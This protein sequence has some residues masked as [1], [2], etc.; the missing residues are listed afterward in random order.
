MSF[1][2]QD[3]TIIQK[4]LVD[5]SVPTKEE[6]L[7][8]EH[9]NIGAV[10]KLYDDVLAIRETLA[11]FAK[12][13]FDIPL[14][15]RGAVWGHLK[16][17]QA[18]LKHLAWQV[19]QVAAGDLSQRVD[20]MGDFSSAFNK[21]TQQLEDSLEKM[22][23]REAAERMQI[24]FDAT[25]LCCSFWNE[26]QE[27]LDCNLEAVK[28]HELDNKR[29]YCERFFDLSPE[30]QPDGRRSV[31][32]FREKLN[33]AFVEGYTQCEFLR[34][35]INGEP[36]PVEITFVRVLQQEHYIVACY[37]R[38]LRELK[39]QQAALDRQRQLLLDVFSSSP[40][41]FAILADGKVKF[42]SAFMTHF[43]GLNIDDPFIDCF[44][45]KEKGENLLSEVKKE[46]H[47]EWEPVTLCSK[48]HGVKEMLANLFLTEYYGEQGMIVWLVDVTEIKM[49]EAD[50][51]AAKETAERLGLVKDE[52]I[53]NMSHELR[54]PMNAVLG[55]IHLLHHTNLSEEQVSFV[56]TM[57]ASA[58][59]L[60]QIINDVLDFSK[61]ESGKV[62]MHWEDF[63]VRETLTS[64]Q[65]TLREDVE[66]KNLSLSCSIEEGVPTSLSGDPERLRQVLL[67][68]TDNA[69]KF[70]AE[71]SV[72]IRV[73]L[74]SSELEKVI[75][76]FSV[77]DTGIGMK[78]EDKEQIFRP[79]SQVDTSGTRKYGGTGLGLT[80][81]KSLVELMGGRIWSE[82]ELQRG[83][84]FFFTA[85]FKLPKEK[86]P[87]EI[88]F[89]ESFQGLPVLLAEDN[90]INQIVATK[91]L[92]E[93]GFRVDV[94]PN[95]LRAVEMVKQ[96]DYALVFMD[97]QMPEMDG[98]QATQIIRSDAKYAFLPIVALTANAM[99]DDR[100]QCLEAGMNDHVAKPIEPEIL[101]RT[102]LRW[103]NPVAETEP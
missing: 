33:E 88:V 19:E 44:A 52:F 99:K 9:P 5:R 7:S 11:H 69:V 17:L 53:A 64:V 3:T 36:M 39:R 60:L 63:D 79:F 93:K 56:G 31:E 94:A 49:I 15:G 32:V 85:E 72:Q 48:E 35:D 40:I 30:Y 100:R 102:I 82:S 29:E 25:P 68:L 76:L 83:S 65:I 41:C 43:L 38:D 91:L 8:E 45:D 58:K 13:E 1:S 20:F 86:K 98:I 78:A 71:G 24:M 74:E 81:A 96:K 14:A 47:I 22:K 23:N 77:Q 97:I 6:Y 87:E 80:V 73:Q 2:E 66:A 61:I 37:I 10:A 103:A 50:L 16:A 51:R 4:L 95:G 75:L 59:H 28:L 84:T 90:K 70:T 67:S 101:Y 18:N 62:I 42:S 12:G 26:Q 92:Q 34:Q 46:V 54:T 21:L 57:E 27:I 55:M 89:P